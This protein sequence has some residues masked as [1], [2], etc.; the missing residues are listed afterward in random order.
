MARQ[1]PESV[2]TAV[3]EQV[4]DN[5]DSSPAVQRELLIAL[6]E[7][8]DQRF[9]QAWAIL[10]AYGNDRDRWLLEAMGIAADGRWDECL[11]SRSRT[12]WW[13]ASS[14]GTSSPS[15]RG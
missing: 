8:K 9:A 11:S 10:V 15:T 3:L 7:S 13:W 1:M 4:F 12:T 5:Q 6:R 2:K 14:H